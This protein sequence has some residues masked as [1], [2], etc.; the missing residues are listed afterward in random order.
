[1]LGSRL[2]GMKPRL[3]IVKTHVFHGVDFIETDFIPDFEEGY[4]GL[5]CSQCHWGYA[6]LND[7]TGR[8]MVLE[9]AREHAL[10]EHAKSGR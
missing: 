10:R 4:A 1:M 2:R 8:E 9:K 6:F 5:Y 3:K 7:P